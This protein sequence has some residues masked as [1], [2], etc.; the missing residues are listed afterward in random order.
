MTYDL[1]I[2]NGRIVDGSGTP[3]FHGDV[4]I[5]NGKIAEIGKLRGA[6]AR[7]VN[8][9]GLVVAPGF[10]DNHCHYDA[11]VTWD[12]L[13][14]YSCYHG[15]TTV[16]IG[17]CSLALAPVRRGA[18]QRLA[19]FLSQVEAIPM[20]SLRTVDM[21]WETIPEYMA[22]LD[23]SLGVNVG[24][25]IGHTAIRHYVMD[26]ESQGR[27]ATPAEIESMRGIVRD[28]IQAGALG[29]SLNTNKGHYDPHGEHIPAYWASEE[30]LFALGDVLAELGTGVIQAGGGRESELKNRLMTRL[31]DATGRQV[32][33]NALGQSFRSPDAWKKHMALVEDTVKSGIRANPMCTSKSTTNRFTMRNT[34]EFRSVPTWHPILTAPDEEKLRAYSDPEIR[35]K[36]H[37]EVVEWT[38]EIPGNTLTRGWVDYMWVGETKLAKNKWLEGKTLRALGAAQGKGIIDAMLDLAVEENLDTVFLRA[39]ANTDKE[40]MTR[41]LNSP[42]TF[43]GL[44]DA[45]AHV[46]FQGGYGY[47]SR[48]LGYWVR[49]QNIMSLEKAVRRLTFDN[50]SAFGIYDRGLL[51]PGL[52]ADITIFDPDTVN[53]LREEVV[54]DLPA[55][56]WRMRELAAGI[57]YTIVNGEVLLENGRHSGAL[58]GRVL[59]NALYHEMNPA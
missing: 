55:G 32:L 51:Q 13:C 28:A 23:R 58:P 38:V 50:A 36:L 4:G 20:E 41:I 18:E 8:A 54:H 27:V 2:K 47:S 24:N 35:R 53:P 3:A 21:C 6:A 25:L 7:A 49:E 37:K 1:L 16:I 44:S 48:L 33:Y 46:Q 14:S 40:A 19:E 34:Q 9:D 10:I 59:R 31:A 15:A 5:R 30:E 45:G 39:A 17:N 12:P 42:S 56:A 22:V 57:H 29:L 11:Q 52:A 43:I 26:K